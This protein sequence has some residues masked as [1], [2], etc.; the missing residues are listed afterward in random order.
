MFLPEPGGELLQREATASQNDLIITCHGAHVGQTQL[1]IQETT[2]S[3]L[4]ILIVEG[5]RQLQVRMLFHPL[6]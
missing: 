6:P 4:G 1:S 3:R 5:D 2:E